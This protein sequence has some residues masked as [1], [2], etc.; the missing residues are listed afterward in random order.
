M[1][2]RYLFHVV[3]PSCNKLSDVVREDRV[4]DPAVSCGDCLMDKAEV[5]AMKV[6]KVEEVPYAP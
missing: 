2:R 1:K 3:C 6:V 5:V 4:P